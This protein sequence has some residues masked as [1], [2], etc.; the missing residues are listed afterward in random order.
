MTG[1][2]IQIEVRGYKKGNWSKT[3]K[4]S[5]SGV[6]VWKHK[7]EP[8]IAVKLPFRS[9]ATVVTSSRQVTVIE[10]EIAL[11]CSTIS[12]RRFTQARR[13]HCRGQYPDYFSRPLPPCFRVS[14]WA[15]ACW[16][17]QVFTP[18][19]SSMS[20]DRSY[21]CP[22][23]RKDGINTRLFR[24]FDLLP[25]WR[26]SSGVASMNRWFKEQRWPFIAHLIDQI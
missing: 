14:C 19:A 20:G 25:P 7:W 21:G 18:A 2:W 8:N 16:F 24:P 23:H 11:L 3:G 5:W 17:L 10:A 12:W 6:V 9:L 15:S 4:R 26:R 13:G 22:F 1:S